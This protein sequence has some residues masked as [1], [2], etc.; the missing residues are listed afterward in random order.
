MRWR[1]LASRVI[2]SCVLPVTGVG[3]PS[4]VNGVVGPAVLPFDESSSPVCL[5]YVCDW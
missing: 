5:S 3:W 1:T 4:I 2:V